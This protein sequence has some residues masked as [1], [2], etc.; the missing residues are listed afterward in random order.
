MFIIISITPVTDHPASFPLSAD[1]IFAFAA[2][3]IQVRFFNIAFGRS[4]VPK[5]AVPPSF[6]N[7]VLVGLVS[8]ENMPHSTATERA[9][10]PGQIG[11]SI[12]LDNNVSIHSSD[13]VYHNNESQFYISLHGERNYSQST[14]SGRG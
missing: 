6:R 5:L 2:A 8:Q 1:S 7:W 13:V 4:S 11:G 12:M 14:F 10:G 3:Q 9:V